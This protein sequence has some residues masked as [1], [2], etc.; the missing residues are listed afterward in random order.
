MNAHRFFSF[1]PIFLVIL[2]LLIPL[3]PN[4]ILNRNLSDNLFL[5]SSHSSDKDIADN[6]NQLM[7]NSFY[8]PLY[9]LSL[10]SSEITV[11]ERLAEEY[12]P[13]LNDGDHIPGQCKIRRHRS[14]ALN[15]QNDCL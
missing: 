9:F 1:F 14:F 5:N 4:S 8:K 12:T 2:F 10:P 13:F 11:R 15:E 7:E 3:S 6:F